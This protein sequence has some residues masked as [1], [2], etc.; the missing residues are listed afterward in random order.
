MPRRSPIIFSVCMGLAGL[1]L[2]A[3]VNSVL[4]L[5][6]HDSAQNQHKHSAD[7]SPQSFGHSNPQTATDSDVSP[8]PRTREQE[9]LALYNRAQRLLSH[10]QSHS[11]LVPP[12]TS[13]HPPISIFSPSS[14]TPLLE[15]SPWFNRGGFSFILKLLRK[16]ESSSSGYPQTSSP[17]SESKTSGLL[18]ILG[19]PRKIFNCFGRTSTRITKSG[20]KS[21]S[22]KILG[23][24]EAEE[25]TFRSIELLNKA[26]FE[27]GNIDAGMTLG[28]LWLWGGSPPSVIPRN[29]HKAM[30]AFQW[31]ADLT[32]NATA[33]ANLA[34]LYAS[35]YGGVLGQNL[36][37]VGDQS[38]ALLHYT[39]AALGGDFPAEISL[40]YRH[41]VGIGT[42]QS[43]RE[44]LPF[45]KSAAEKSMRSFNSGPPGGRHMPPV[46]VRLSD[47][48]GGVYGPGASV[49]ST[50]NNKL[51]HSPQ[52]PVTIQAWND[53][54]E[55]YQFHA[56]RGDASFMFRLG[57]IYY[58]GFGTV[59][60]NIQ[61]FA[62]TNGRNY[63]K[64]LKW[65]NRI[66]RTVWPRDPEAATSPSG[67]AFQNKLGQWQ[68]PMVGAYDS[69]KDVKLTADET[70]TV[71][72]GL[73]AGFL[74]RLY[75]RGE[76]VP[77][78]YAK[79]FLWFSRGASQGDRESQ[80][81]LGV[82]Y[83]D[84]LGVQRNIEK[85]VNYF[86][87]AANAELADAYVNLGKYYMDIDPL[88]SIPHFDN[89]IK[90]GD[91]YQSYYYLAEINTLNFQQFNRPELCP[92]AVAFYKR[93]A[94]RGDWFEEVFWKSEKAWADGDEATALLG[95]WMMAERG[96]EVAQNNVAYLL[97]RHKKGIRLPKEW[98][99]NN[100]T[101]RLALTYWTR[102]AAQDNIDALVKMGDYYLHGYGT[103]SGQP[104]PEKAAACYQT[105]T[106]THLSAMA[107]WN[108]GWLHENGI[109]V[110]Q[111]YHLA[112]RFYDL[113]LETNSEASLPV[114]LSLFNLY[115]RSLWGYIVHGEPKYLSVFTSL[116][117]DPTGSGW[118]S[119][120]RLRDEITRRWFGIAPPPGAGQVQGD[121]DPNQNRDMHISDADPTN[122]QRALQQD[123]NPV[124]LVRNARER[125]RRMGEDGEEEDDLFLMTSPG[126]DFLETLGILILCLGLGA[127]MFFR[128]QR[129]ANAARIEAER[130]NDVL[131]EA[132]HDF[133]QPQELNPTINNTN[134]ES[135]MN[136]LA[137]G[138]EPTQTFN[139]ATNITTSTSGDSSQPQEVPGE[140]K[141]ESDSIRRRVRP[142]RDEN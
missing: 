89:A 33:Q 137:A 32:G 6:Q 22:A 20:R 11:H 76:G 83:R 129:E 52:Q 53:V 13:L 124:E 7:H 95:F 1:A 17:K 106:N 30:E 24:R 15:D 56:E 62:L 61:D 102:S 19:F 14:Y 107:M 110:S 87:L 25:A 92:I 127:F 82:M 63:L 60:D 29:P 39:F 125:E 66:A 72:A 116:T 44:A 75:L 130:Q 27:F 142:V 21:A 16:F 36:T 113:A 91:S 98:N 8:P 140:R 131:P 55:F 79:A 10:V 38:A 133:I 65:F 69:T 80:N 138:H 46:K 90:H 132:A 68:T 57:R 81:G 45:Y 120:R 12:H 117:D 41:W 115:V 51:Y 73:S 74:G 54:L 111:D 139:E 136:Q 43:C 58:Q 78:N 4:A 18:L 48:E 93:V 100:S 141:E 64:A 105:A 77:R 50:G 121:D 23:Q 37:Y 59:G 47:R 71:A 94:E 122:T 123:E 103:I 96:Y 99:S 88:A 84:G 135:D 108:L 70:Q 67:H 5:H 126:D 101:D 104:Q 40:G 85:A 112:K 35:G 119:L 86:Q 31:V 3:I 34:F 118:W 128:Q 134:L 49:A 26:A 114:T 9:G 42:K 109:G 28:N 97:D 2:I